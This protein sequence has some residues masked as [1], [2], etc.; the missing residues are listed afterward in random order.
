M[1]A[2]YFALFCSH[3]PCLHRSFVGTH[4][5]LYPNRNMPRRPSLSQSLPRCPS[6][7]LMNLHGFHIL[8][9]LYLPNILKAHM[10]HFKV[11]M[12]FTGQ[13]WGLLH[14]MRD[15][16]FHTFQVHNGCSRLPI[17][18]CREN[19]LPHPLLP[20]FASSDSPTDSSLALL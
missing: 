12:T 1:A 14:Q 6:S 18:V 19:H 4:L 9:K 3:S 8:A 13:H 5:K 20:F 2:D 11:L 17:A 10:R 7:L 16:S 15:W